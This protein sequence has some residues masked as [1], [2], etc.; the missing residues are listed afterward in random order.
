[1]ILDK[2]I[3]RKATHRTG[4]VLVDQDLNILPHT[5]LDVFLSHDNRA[6]R[7]VIDIPNPAYREGHE[8]LIHLVDE[9][10]ECQH[11]PTIVAALG[12]MEVDALYYESIDV[13]HVKTARQQNRLK[14]QSE[15]LAASLIF[16]KDSENILHVK[17]AEP[18]VLTISAISEELIRYL[19]KHPNEIYNLSSRKFEE[20]IAEILVGF[21]WEVELTAQTQDGGYDIFAISGDINSSGIKTSFIVECKKYAPH[22]K[23][24]IE[25]ARQLFF[26]KS[27]LNV[28]NAIIATT[29]DFTKGVYDFRSRRLDF[30]TKNLGNI[31]DWC[32]NYQNRRL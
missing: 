4:L 11:E 17:D 20:L 29:S 24:G 28:S 27:E 18:L 30:D 31:V 12:S 13:G 32:K 21:G 14:K 3:N 16:S 15:R 5:A 9:L 23:V 10:I 7:R 19:G 22:R 25:V 8:E 26:V 1:M 6:N 2:F